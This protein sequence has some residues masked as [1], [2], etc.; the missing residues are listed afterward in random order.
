MSKFKEVVGQVGV[1]S[2]AFALTQFV[3]VVGAL[4]IRYF[5]GPLQTG[6]WSLVQVILSYT[7]YANLGATYAILIE[8]PFKRAQGKIEETEKMKNVMFSFSFMTSVLF[9]FGLLIY[10]FV[11][12][13]SIPVELF[14]GLL[15]ATGLVIL[16]Q[17]NNIL[18][19]LLRAYKHFN[20]A[21]KQ[22][23]LSSIVN[24]L[25]VALLSSSFK[26][27]GFMWAM[28]LSFLFNIVYIFYHKPLRFQW[29]LDTKI[30]GGLIRYGFPLMVL[31]FAGT[32]LLTIDKM[33][34]AK[35]LGL[36]AL[37]L[38]SIAVMT[39]GFISSVPNSIGI[40][41]LPNVSE[42]YAEGENVMD[43]RGYLTK[44]NH[45]FSVLMPLLVGFGWFVVPLIVH[46]IIP[47]FLNGIPA[48]KYLVLST[49]FVG[50]TQAYSNFIIV[51]KKHLRQ[52]PI[53]LG[54]CLIAWTSIFLII[55]MGMGING[56]ALA[57]TAVMLC[58]F[59]ALFLFVGR[60]VFNKKELLGEY[61]AV[62]A[63]FAFMV[64]VLLF[65]DRQFGSSPN[66]MSAAGRS[67]ALVILYFPF[68]L[69]INKKYAVWPILREKLFKTKTSAKDESHGA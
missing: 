3:S 54:M 63:H 16:Q 20:L 57:M 7:D 35:F 18:I 13:S 51:S 60:Y 48:L 1:Y 45:L 15:M 26:L 55:K 12:Q 59:S 11:R 29:Q 4:L 22:M 39:A 37:G 40:V 49:F 66:F 68:M 27:Y 25:L 34:I 46:L 36:E 47:R 61:L 32:V 67:I 69:H 44:S 17:L 43:L 10:A 42:K 21:G 19:S 56:V 24:L 28:A 23:A 14:Y 33:M 41:L 65:L 5:L 58:N 2:S 8:I 31:T 38:Y 52:F 50:I 6:V 64:L 62:L 9:S 53:M 30:L